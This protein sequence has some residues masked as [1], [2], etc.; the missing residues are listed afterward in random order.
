[1]TPATRPWTAQL[2]QDAHRLHAQKV[3]AFAI[4]AVV[5]ISEQRVRELLWV[6]TGEPRLD[7]NFSASDAGG[8]RVPADVRPA[9]ECRAA[10]TPPPAPI[11]A[12]C[13]MTV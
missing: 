3:S 7:P 10:G 4:A 9:G 11:C 8:S 2:V 12:E 6:K 1:M 13:G 5:G